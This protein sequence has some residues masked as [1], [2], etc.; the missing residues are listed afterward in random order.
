MGI[1]KLRRAFLVKEAFV[2]QNKRKKLIEKYASLKKINDAYR[3]RSLEGRI[4]Q[5]TNKL[6]RLDLTITN[7]KE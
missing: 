4:A 1:L 7:Y 5:C 2:L 6:N 3:D